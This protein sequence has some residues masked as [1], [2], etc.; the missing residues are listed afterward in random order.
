MPKK[1]LAF[2]GPVIG[3]ALFVVAGFALSH[4]LR[5]QSLASILQ[6]ME[7][8]P[9]WRL[10]LAI[11]FVVI[12]YV[13]LAF[14]DGLAFQFLKERVPFKSIFLVSFISH[15]ITNSVG[16]GVLTGTSVRFRFYAARGVSMGQILKI[17]AFGTLTFFLGF[18][19]ILGVVLTVFPPAI[20]VD[21]SLPFHS[22]RILGLIFLTITVA[23]LLW[24]G[25]HNGKTFRLFGYAFSF[26]PL[27]VSL[28][29]ILVAFAEWIS[30]AM[31]VYCLLSSAASLPF[32]HFL[33]MYLLAL[34]VGI[35]SQVPGGLGVFESV[36]LALLPAD[37]PLSEVVAALLIYRVIYYIL[38]LILA[39]ILLGTRE[40]GFRVRQILHLFAKH[41]ATNHASA[42]PHAGS[43]NK[44]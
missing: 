5:G 11:T 10:V 28:L 36:L 6:A 42:S 16:F 32:T 7:Q 30:V 26:P 17:V 43:S 22:T 35:V 20:P 41:R 3:L 13:A 40:G 27:R 24:S 18:S 9:A 14:Y 39:V 33:G 23:Y 15:T 29:Q 8:V 44:A 2:L 12:S 34:F 19:A 31:I 4:E 1:L 37:I 38:P 21:F 25:F